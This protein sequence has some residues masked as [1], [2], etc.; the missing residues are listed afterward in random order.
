MRLVSKASVD[1]KMVT[2]GSDD[3]HR[4]AL[5]TAEKMSTAADALAAALKAMDAEGRIYRGRLD[6]KSV[7]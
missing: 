3:V 2:P 7:V 5:K 4:L 6:R 1:G